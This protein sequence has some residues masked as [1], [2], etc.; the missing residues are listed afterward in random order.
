MVED[1]ARGK[2]VLGSCIGTNMDSPP[3]IMIAR[4][5]QARP[6][7]MEPIKKVLPCDANLAPQQFGGPHKL[8][9]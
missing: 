2:V 8:A 7:A 6:L 9:Y 5:G 3:V 4:K 1:H